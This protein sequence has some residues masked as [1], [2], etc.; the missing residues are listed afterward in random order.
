MVLGVDEVPLIKLGFAIEIFIVLYHS[1]KGGLGL[2]HVYIERPRRCLN[3]GA[4]EVL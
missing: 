3:E 2:L 1:H 4:L